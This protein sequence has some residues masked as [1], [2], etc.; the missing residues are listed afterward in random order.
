MSLYSFI[1]SIECNFLNNIL[2]IG[3]D[4]TN[5]NMA[6]QISIASDFKLFSF[7]GL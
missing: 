6:A 1:L 3:F 4:L 5:S 2:K 7:P